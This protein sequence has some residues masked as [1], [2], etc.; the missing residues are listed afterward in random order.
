MKGNETYQK[1]AAKALRAF[2]SR[3]RSA[4][5]SLPQMLVALMHSLAVPKQIVLAGDRAE[6]EPFIDAIGHRF[7]PQHALLW[8]GTRGLDQAISNMKPIE[9]KPAAYVCENFT[10]KLPVS[11]VAEFERLLQ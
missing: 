4:P 3:M 7:L 1:T 11:D 10:C 9:D 5:T 6:L 2:G 8:S